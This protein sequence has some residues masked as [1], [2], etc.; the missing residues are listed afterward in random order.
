MVFDSIICA[1]FHFSVCVY[2]RKL[3]DPHK[4]ILHKQT[5]K[6]LV[7]DNEYG[8]ERNSCDIL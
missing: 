2:T 4:A 3:V 7:M 5:D 8:D 6:K 1:K